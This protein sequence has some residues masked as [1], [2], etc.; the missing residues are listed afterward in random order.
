M[1]RSL[2]ACSAPLIIA[3]LMIAASSAMAQVERVRPNADEA[4]KGPSLECCKCLGATTTLDLSTVSSNKWTVNN[5]LVAF[6]TNIHSMWNINPGPAQWVS[7]V[8]S[9]GTSNLTAGIYEYRLRF[10][11][12]P[13]AIERRVTLTGNFGGDDDVAVYLDNTTSG[14]LIAQCTQG[15]CFNTP[16]KTL[17]TLPNNT[18][19]GSGP[20][21][22]IVRVVNGS[23]SPTG[24]FVNAKLTGVCRN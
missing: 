11:V 3:V 14:N 2:N 6:L 15:W 7:T 16:Q 19:I 21:V 1:S 18:V 10:V 20:H 4:V 8:A 13:C 22:L 17:S 12:P 24:M 23:D 5:N 9:G